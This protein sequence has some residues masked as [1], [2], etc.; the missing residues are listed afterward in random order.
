MVTVPVVDI[1]S[2]GL[3]A[4]PNVQQQAPESAYRMADSLGA[5]A[6]QESALGQASEGLTNTAAD[7][8]TKTAELAARAQAQGAANSLN[9]YAIDQEFNPQTG[10][11][12]QKGLQALQRDSGVPLAQE[13]G[14][15]L[16]D[17]AGDLSATLTSPLAKQLFNEQ[18]QQTQTTFQ[19]GIQ[20]HV[21]QQFQE[22][23]QS[24][25][26]GA[27]DLA[28]QTAA[29][30]WQDPDAIDAAVQSAQTGVRS[31]LQGQLPD[32]D[33]GSQGGQGGQGASANM[34]QSALNVT[35]STIRSKVI[36]S[37]LENNNPTYAMAY[38][39]KYKSA[40]TAD[41][42]LRV[43]SKL[44][45]QVDQH[46]A[47]D[48]VQ[49]T[50]KDNLHLLAPTTSDRAYNLANNG[51][52][53]AF[54]VA[55]GTES[56][57]QQF[58]PDG[59]TPLTSSKGATGV[60]QVMPATGPE[61]A[62]LAGLPWDAN[63]FANDKNYNYQLGLAYFNKQVKDFGGM[64]KAYAAY[65]AGPGATQDAIAQAK[66]DGKPAMWLS[67]L[68][69]ET[70][71][72]VTKNTAALQQ[73][74]GVPT[75]PTK[76]EFVTAAIS[77][78]K[79]GTDPRPQVI[80]LIR[81]QAEKQYDLMLASR[82]EQGE[83]AVSAV[84]RTL[85]QNGGD[86]GQVSPQMIADVTNYAPDKLGDM[87]KY[88]KSIASPAMATNVA[89]YAD[90]VTYPDKLASMSDS[91]FTTY[92]KTNFSPGRDQDHI[93]MVRSDAI[94]GKSN[95]SFQSLNSTA[96][97]GIIDNRLNSIGIAPG[98]KG[99]TDDAAQ[100]AIIRKF[101]ADDIYQQQTQLGRKMKPEELSNRVDTLFANKATTDGWWQ[102]APAS[103][104]A[105]KPSN[106]PDSDMSQIKASLTKQGHPD[107]SDE[108]LL[109]TYWNWKK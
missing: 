57:G 2:A 32:A 4:L 71:D 40:M 14:Q 77:P 36:D 98:A 78:D 12:Q 58:G 50:T 104:L 59:V 49:A 106:I 60:A 103:M 37:A 85:D 99:G 47:L 89:A 109:R 38:F 92:L 73:G 82:K 86:M 27:V 83:N 26:K 105:M 81:E 79:I 69:K 5:G 44:N 95:D 88:A 19:R 100:V 55:V 84:Q 54:Q 53:G 13:Y 68:P 21:N 31:L 87:Y 1:P 22:Y 65:N 93:A 97:K 39:N 43:Q 63:K 74:G 46:V 70:Q 15:N 16:Q 94:N 18:A 42:I 62:A 107:P 67:Y 24:V 25:S 91:D 75:P 64:D 9:Q 102:S 90:A 96:L 72:Y 45:T 101:I 30:K 52:A 66:A 10:Y 80:N 51:V 56:N 7:I 41:D 17:K 61:A 8:A 29:L 34:L 20:S 3:D 33:T 23:S 76:Q 108:L 11:Q 6:K 28:A 48:A 35:E